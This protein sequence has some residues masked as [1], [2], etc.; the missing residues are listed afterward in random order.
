MNPMMMNPAMMAQMMSAMQGGMGGAAGAGAQGEHA[1][2]V[3][4]G[5]PLTFSSGNTD[6]FGRALKRSR[7]D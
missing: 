5:L 3:I 2:W 7:Q 1:C 6:E 4:I